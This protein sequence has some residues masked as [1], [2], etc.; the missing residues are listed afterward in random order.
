MD[1]MPDKI[2]SVDGGTITV[3]KKDSGIRALKVEDQGIPRG[4]PHE[5]QT[6]LIPTFSRGMPTHATGKLTSSGR[7]KLLQLIP[8]GWAGTALQN[9]VGGIETNRRCKVQLEMAGYTAR[10]THLHSK[11]Q[12]VIEA[13]FFEWCD[14]ELGIPEKYP[15]DPKDMLTGI[16]AVENNPWRLSGKFNRIA[17]W[18]PH[19]AVPEN[20][21]WDVGG[22]KMPYMLKLEPEPKVIDAWQMAAVWFDE[23]TQHQKIESISPFFA[24]RRKLYEWAEVQDTVRRRLRVHWNSNHDI[25]VVQSRVLET[26]VRR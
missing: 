20:D 18:H 25:R 9:D 23:A 10:E 16:W 2:K 11:E 26:E 13:S 17:G 19:A 4:I 12:T 8:F 7:P 6:V 14:K 15:Y 1:W 24:P 22:L 5:T 21:H 3:L